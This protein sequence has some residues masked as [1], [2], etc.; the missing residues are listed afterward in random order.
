[1]SHTTAA[2]NRRHVSTEEFADR[3]L[4]L[5]ETI[6][7][8]HSRTGQY[9]GIR[10]VRLPNRRLAWPVHEIERLFESHNPTTSLKETD[11]HDAADNQS[12]ETEQLSRRLSTAA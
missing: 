10:P 6:L 5:P 3:V 8:C 1:M 11:S 2:L 12:V 7:K 9:A 4:V